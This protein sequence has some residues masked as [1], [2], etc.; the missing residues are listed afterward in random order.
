MTPPDYDLGA[1]GQ[2]PPAR[3]LA[4]LSTP[5]MLR[6]RA[7]VRLDIARQDLAAGDTWAARRNQGVATAMLQR[8][9]TAGR[10]IG[11]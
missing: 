1:N 11:Q 10:G 2:T 9:E 4:M 3:I 6:A 5:A 8:A 7:A